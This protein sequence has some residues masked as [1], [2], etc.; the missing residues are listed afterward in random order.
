MT[1]TAPAPARRP[2]VDDGTT[3]RHARVAGGLYLVTFL[4]SIP[5]LVLIGP[6]LDRADYVVSAGADSRV[7]VGCL[8]DLVNAVA[9]VGTAVALFPVLR[10]HGEAVALGFVTSRMF[11]AAVITT[12]VVCLLGVVT[13]RQDGAG[14][15]GAEATALT[16]TAQGLV[17][18]RDWTF[19][20]GPSF[21]A[22][23]N[24]LLLGSLLFRSRLVPR[25]IPALGLL[26]APLLLAAST[27]VF[28]DLFDQVSAP[29][30]VATLPVAAWELSVGLWM[31]LRGFRTTTG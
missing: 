5:A 14:A 9:C 22:A 1:I 7:L 21:M 24:A 28:F 26:G 16:A 12:G 27:A 29:A 4:A 8:L 23:V 19:L 6:V 17:A 15:T 2:D 10:H 3:R 31:L 30:G 20:L 25:W 11:E 18:V 13:L